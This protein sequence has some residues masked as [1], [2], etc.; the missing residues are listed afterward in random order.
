MARQAQSHTELT[1]LDR[2]RELLFKVMNVKIDSRTLAIFSFLLPHILRT[3]VFF[4]TGVHVLIRKY[5]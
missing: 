3:P 2:K 1:K 4:Q 5:N